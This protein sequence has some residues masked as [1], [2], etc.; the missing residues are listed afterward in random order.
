MSWINWQGLLMKD[1]MGPRR[2]TQ[3]DLGKLGEIRVLEAYMDPGDE[4]LAPE[5]LGRRIDD[6]L[7]DSIWLALWRLEN[8]ATSTEEF[9]STMDTIEEGIKAH[10]ALVAF[11][12]SLG[13]EKEGEVPLPSAKY[14]ELARRHVRH[15]AKSVP[16]VEEGSQI[17]RV[18]LAPF[19]NEALWE[20][21][22]DR[23]SLV[24]LWTDSWLR[25]RDLPQLWYYILASKLS[26]VAWDTL[27]AICQ[28]LV[29][30]GEEDIPRELLEWHFWS[31]HGSPQRPADD[32]AESHRPR[33]KLGRML[34]NNEIRHMVDLLAQVGMPGK[35]DEPETDRYEAVA[36]GIYLAR[37]TV[38]RI[39]GEPYT[40]IADF[41]EE[42]MKR[43]EPSYYADLYDS[44]SNSDLAQALRTY[45]ESR[46]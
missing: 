2:Q 8:H 6:G 36:K 27:K 37:L 4:L 3:V 17:A 18:L 23:K 7:V 45:L 39:C 38:S 5:K 22:L 40:T 10:P 1:S 30:R 14:L 42:A 31:S 43:L 20:T 29:A 9:E 15:G 25:S 32:K 19:R 12:E 41:G 26:P 35:V 24:S 16:S 11:K 46:S 44:D 28:Q 33:G 34:R 13:E 21:D